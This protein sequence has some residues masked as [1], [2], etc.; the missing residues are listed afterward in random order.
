MQKPNLGKPGGNSSEGGDDDFELEGLDE[1]GSKFLVPDDDYKI[2]LTGL[3]KEVSNAGNP[4]WVWVWTIIEGPEAGKD[5][6]LWTAITAGALWKMQQVL[7]AIG[8]HDGESPRVKFSRSEAL[9]RTCI[10]TFKQEPYQG[11]MTSKIASVRAED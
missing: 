10:G 7:A 1:I 4:M 3:T 11:R 6:K 9:G 8:L 5:F 2:K